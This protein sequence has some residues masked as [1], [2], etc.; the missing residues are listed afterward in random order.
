MTFCWIA[1]RLRRWARRRQRPRRD[2]RVLSLLVLEGRSVP[3]V[4]PLA[5]RADFAPIPVYRADET[6]LD[7]LIR[8]TSWNSTEVPGDDAETTANAPPKS[9]APLS[10]AAFVGVFLGSAAVF[11]YDL[12]ADARAS[13]VFHGA[14]V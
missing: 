2:R 7:G 9:G 5:P 1:D 4:T 11:D 10:V 13:A 6:T 3:S 8:L 12:E 14:K